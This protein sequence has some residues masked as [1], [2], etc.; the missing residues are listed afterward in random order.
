VHVCRATCCS[1]NIADR[2][3]G[4][5]VVGASCWRHRDDQVRA[6]DHANRTCCVI[7]VVTPAKQ[8]AHHHCPYF[9]RHLAAEQCSQH[10]RLICR[11][12]KRQKPF[13][14]AN[15]HC[16]DNV[17]SELCLT[18]RCCGCTQRRGTRRLGSLLPAACLLACMDQ[19]IFVAKCRRQE[20]LLIRQSWICVPSST[21]PSRQL[22]LKFVAELPV[23]GA[24]CGVVFAR[25]HSQGT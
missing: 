8:N 20:P 25:G 16:S 11:P 4:Y 24:C 17:V 9:N 22:C 6:L 13:T 15:E 19:H 21:A 5:H 3:S 12:K 23:S 18:A 1:R 14:A 2:V 7:M 10:V